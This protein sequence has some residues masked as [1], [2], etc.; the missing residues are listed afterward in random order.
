MCVCEGHD[1]CM[2]GTLRVGCLG[3]LVGEGCLLEVSVGGALRVGC[4]GVLRGLWEM[5]IRGLLGG[6]LGVSTGGVV[7][8]DV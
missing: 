5:S 1:V 3:V 2:R 8:V 7:V 4:L 6:L